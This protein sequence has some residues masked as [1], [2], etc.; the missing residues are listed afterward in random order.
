MVLRAPT[1]QDP[2][3][4][5][6]PT[7]KVFR[8]LTTQSSTAHCQ[9]STLTGPW[10]QYRFS[11]MN[12]NPTTSTS[13]PLSFLQ[14]YQ[15]QRERMLRQ[16]QERENRHQEVTT[17]PSTS[18]HPPPSLLP[19]SS[20]HPPHIIPPFVPHTTIP[21]SHHHSLSL[22]HTSLQPLTTILPKFCPC[23]LS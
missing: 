21:T 3:I 14:H 5:R 4:I 20:H 7:T 11:L 16:M 22:P 1:C 15:Q 19:S 18:S 2:R 23:R 10:T 17:S 8:V 9:G 12:T 13:R 6:A